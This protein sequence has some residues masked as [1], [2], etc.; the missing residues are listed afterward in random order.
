MDHFSK[1]IHAVPEFHFPIRG[2]FTLYKIDPP[3]KRQENYNHEPFEKTC[4]HL[5]KD[6]YIDVSGHWTEW[7]W[8]SVGAF[9]TYEHARLQEYRDSV[10]VAY[11]LYNRIGLEHLRRLLHAARLLDVGGGTGRKA[12]P[13]AQQGF[14]H[15]TVLDHAPEWLRLADEKANQANVRHRLK[16][17]EGDVR[18]MQALDD[19][20]FDYVFA[21]GGV[22]S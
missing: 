9:S 17:L 7:D 4:A 2:T 21:L 12:I 16:L 18:H 11:R 13:L 8:Q 20:S 10:I 1:E 3:K 22:L 14:E 15:I 19:G 5:I 6:L